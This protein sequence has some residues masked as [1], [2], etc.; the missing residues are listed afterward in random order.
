MNAKRRKSMVYR[1]A[2]LFAVMLVLIAVLFSR[3]VYIQAAKEVQGEDLRTMIESRW[4]DSRTLHGKRGSILDR[5]GEII[6]EEISSYTIVAILDDRYDRYVDDPLETASELAN[7]LDMDKGLLTDYLSRD[8]AQVEL[9]PSAKN[10]SY[11]TMKKVENLDLDGIVFREDPRRYYPRQ[12]FASHVIGY[13]ERDMSV[14]RMG[15][16]NTLNEYLEGEAG[17]ITY[18]RDGRRRPLLNADEQ[19][20]EPVDGADVIL[21]IDSKIQTAMEQTMNQVEED[22]DPER[23]IAIAAHAKTGEIL[24]M[25]NRPGFNPNHYEQ[26]ENYT[27]YAVASRFEPGS[28][29]K[30]FTL[31]A[32]IEED[33]YRGNDTYQSGSYQVTDRTV[34]DH[35]QGRGWGEITFDEGLR[36]SSNVAFSKL[37]LEHL[38]EE[39][40]YDYIQSFGFR[41][42][43]G[44]DLPNETTGMIADTYTI[45][46]ATTSFGQGSAVSPIQQV[47]AA[48]AIANQ[49]QMMK[50]Y[51]VDQIIGGTKGDPVL[52]QK[53][54]VAGNPVSA[55]TANRVL[56]LLETAVSHETGTGRPYAIDGFKVAGKTGTAQIPNEDSPGYQSGHGNY[57]YSFLG[58]APA[59]DPE[60]IVYVAVE[61]PDIEPHVQGNE[62]VSKVFRQVME[63]SLQYLNITPTED[64]EGLP[65]AEEVTMPDH[66]GDAAE[67]TFN[68]LME[69]GFKVKKIGEGN[70][71][72]A[73]SPPPGTEAVNGETVL[74]VTNG[75][76]SMP[77]LTGWSLRSV[78]MLSELLDIE[79]DADGTGFVLHQVPEPGADTAS[80]N[81]LSIQLSGSEM[82][83]DVW[84][85]QQEESLEEEDADFFMD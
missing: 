55:V 44:I 7:V 39:R 15:L 38:G 76:V 64:D 31:A 34:H 49:G 62:P 57:I 72:A 14:A 18:Q 19:I 33:V 13:T 61:K 46:T 28:T 77:D 56:A 9:G 26:I 69:T 30:M 8:A 17:S 53:P 71:V 37:A 66:V 36:R 10:L 47:Q 6:A 83:E 81:R 80:M 22:Y 42:P 70:Q 75:E 2:F 3:F 16:E 67:D 20:E 1:G 40:L 58:M 25:S 41:E 5:N 21:T 68:S 45:D 79:V 51:V 27:N 85:D 73:Q 11:E 84:L 32:A 43:T 74:L 63:Q 24:A 78:Y 4:T 35:N 12:T 82:D 50:P 52:E 29:M 65:F 23:M 59:Q 54:E 60:V 48:T